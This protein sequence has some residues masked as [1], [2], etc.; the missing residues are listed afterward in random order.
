VSNTVFIL[1]LVLWHNQQT[2]AHLILRPKPRN[3]HGDF[4]GQ[5]TKPELPVLRSKPGNPSTM[6]LRLSQETRAPRLL[7]H[8]ADYTQHHPTS[9]SSGHQ[10]P[11]LCLTISDHLHQVSYSFLNPC[12]CLPCRTCHLHTTRQANTFLHATQ[13]IG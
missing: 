11:D 9:R 3:R 2:I 10:V 13:I 1:P 7:V 5:I 12:C 8:G 6:V 4:V